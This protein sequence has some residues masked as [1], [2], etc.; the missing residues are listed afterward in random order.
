VSPNCNRP[1]LLELDRKDQIAS[2]TQREIYR[3]PQDPEKLVKVLRDVPLT[4][5]RAGL[6]VVTEKVLSNA[7]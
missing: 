7:A 3:H 5:G 2:G 6:A 4:K 1:P